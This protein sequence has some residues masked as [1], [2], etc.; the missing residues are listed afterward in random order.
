LRQVL[1]GMDLDPVY[2]L[3]HHYGIAKREATNA[4]RH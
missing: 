1:R 3:R 2:L 4:L